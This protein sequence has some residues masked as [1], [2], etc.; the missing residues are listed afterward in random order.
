MNRLPRHTMLTA[1]S[2]KDECVQISAAAGGRL[3]D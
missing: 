3:I 1:A 2:F